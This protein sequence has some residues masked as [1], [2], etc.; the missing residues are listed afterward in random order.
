V[1]IELPG[2]TLN[3]VYICRVTESL[4]NGDEDHKVMPTW[5]GTT[6]DHDTR[7]SYPE[8]H[9]SLRIQY[10]TP[11]RSHNM[12]YDSYGK[13]PYSNLDLLDGA[14]FGGTAILFA[15]KSCDV[16]QV[17]P[18]ADIAASNDPAQPSMHSSLL[19]EPSWIVLNEGSLG[20]FPGADSADYIEAYEVMVRGG[21]G[22]DTTDAF[23]QDVYYMDSIYDVYDTTYSGAPTY[24]EQPL[25][26]WGELDP[27][28]G[29]AYAHD[30]PYMRF[31]AEG[32]FSIG[33]YQ[34]EFGDTLRYAYAYV[35]GAVSRKTS[36]LM[37][38]AWDDT[39]A[40]WLDWIRQR[41]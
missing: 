39:T 28:R 37:G 1:D 29:Y 13:V 38:E 24:Y 23:F 19:T 3:D 25:D 26:R 8:D 4:L 20:D 18:I 11:M 32:H 17:Y 6:E 41:W 40:G 12:V 27:S 7:L 34:M 5:A 15:P 2:Q 10:V 16:P 30:I 33:P 14:R 35:G 9:D 36:Y 31:D 22:L 21:F